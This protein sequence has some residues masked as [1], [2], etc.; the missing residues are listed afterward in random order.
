VKALKIFIFFFF[1]SFRVFGQDGSDILYIKT[2]KADRSLIGKNVHFDFYNRS[3]GK[4]QIDTIT[5]NIEN[6]PIKFIEIRND[7]GFNNWFSQQSLESI[8]KIDNHTITIPKF[9]LDGITNKSFIVTMYVDFYDANH[10]VID[11]TSRLMKYSF[12]KKDIVEL[13]VKAN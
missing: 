6:N 12:N 3:F 2:K 4:L 11:T 9:R 10:K 5:I 7:D 13:L 1:A 8:D